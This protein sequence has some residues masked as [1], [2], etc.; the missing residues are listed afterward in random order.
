MPSS[1]APLS[2]RRVLQAALTLADSGGAD[3]LTMRHLGREL[4]VEAMSLY[5]HVANKDAVLDGIV[6]MVVDEIDLP[7]ED[8]DW[9]SAMRHRGEAAYR[10]MTRH[11]W[12]PQLLMSRTNTGPAMLRYIDFTLGVLRGA[13]FSWKLADYA[14]NTMDSFVYGYTLRRLTF[15]IPAADYAQT[16]AAH[17]HLLAGG[18]HPH[19]AE[20]T[21]QV[22]EG[23][24]PGDPDITFGLN[25]ILDGLERLRD[26]EPAA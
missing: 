13:G 15:P 7:H 5:R 16:A 18:E 14:W 8:L 19:M 26:T 9:K 21:R 4:G 24:H 6:D 2:T 22:A 11:P 10:V 25:L 1:R 23:N 17:Q 12:A 20:L 3:S